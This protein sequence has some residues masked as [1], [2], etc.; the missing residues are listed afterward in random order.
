MSTQC[1]DCGHKLPEGEAGCNEVISHYKQAAKH[2]GLPWLLTRDE[3]KEL[4]KG[5]CVYCGVEPMQ[6]MRREN[7]LNGVFIYNGIDRLDSNIGYTKTNCAS[8]CKTCN[9]MKRTMGVEQ[10]IA[11]CRKI[12]EYSE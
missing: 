3:A 1:K 8:C 10:F 7:Y 4:F 11:H 5:N 9:Y 12:V 2:R 6:E